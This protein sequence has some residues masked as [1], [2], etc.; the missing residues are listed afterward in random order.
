M[1]RIYLLTYF[2]PN[3]FGSMFIYGSHEF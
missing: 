2:G 3:L 1:T